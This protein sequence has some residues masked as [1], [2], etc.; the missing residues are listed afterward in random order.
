M[1][2]KFGSWLKSQREARNMSKD[3]LGNFAGITASTIAQI[4]AGSIKRP[5]RI[6]LEGFA[7]AFK[8][9][10]AEVEAQL[11]KKK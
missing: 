10:V 2:T 8:I 11:P 6:R 4:E 5:P 3:E 1:A 7:K 9:S